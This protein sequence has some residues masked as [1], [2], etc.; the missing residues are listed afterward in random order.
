MQRKRNTKSHKKAKQTGRNSDWEKFRQLRSKASKAAAKSY[1]DYLNNHIGE[2]LKTNPKQI[3]S[4]IKANK[5]ECIGIPTL[6][7]NGQIIPPDISFY[8]W[9]RPLAYTVT[10]PPL[11]SYNTEPLHPHYTARI[12]TRWIHPQYTARIQ[13]L[14]PQYTA[15]IHSHCIP[16]TPLEYTVTIPQLNRWNA[17]SLYPQYIARIHSHCTPSTQLEKT[18]TMPPVHS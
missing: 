15:I 17:H 18:V 8:S 16:S 11:H 12:N 6:Q 10:T 5:R 7:T 3:W 9:E 14:Y 1:S 13:S 4:F 2:S